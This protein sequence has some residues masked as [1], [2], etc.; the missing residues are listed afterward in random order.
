LDLEGGGGGVPI[1]VHVFRTEADVISGV[2][3]FQSF[4]PSKSEEVSMEEHSWE[5]FMDQN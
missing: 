2:L 3:N 4:N 1:N 5:V